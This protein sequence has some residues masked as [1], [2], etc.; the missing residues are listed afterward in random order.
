MHWDI[1]SAAMFDP[2]WKKPPQCPE[3]R[4]TPEDICVLLGVP[5]EIAVS[6]SQ[7]YIY[8]AALDIFS[9]DEVASLHRE[10]VTDPILRNLFG[11]TKYSQGSFQPALRKMMQECHPGWQKGLG[12]FQANIAISCAVNVVKNGAFNWQAA[13]ANLVDD[14]LLF[15]ANQHS[16]PLPPL[17]RPRILIDYGPGLSGRFVMKEH[18]N[19][20]AKGR[21]FVYAPIARGS[22]IPTFLVSYVSTLMT[23]ES[24]SIYMNNGF[25]APKH[26]GIRAVT[27]YFIQAAP[28]QADVIFCSSLQMVDKQELRAGIENA[29][30]LLRDGGVLLLR[31][32]KT[33]EPAESSTIDDMLDIAFASG[34]SSQ[35]ARYFHSIS[36]GGKATP[37]LSAILI[38][39]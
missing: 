14:T 7:K 34:F 25:F 33:R 23:K 16:Y 13:S 19:A 22:F 31:S 18:L 4:V 29:Y 39:S 9:D 38:K 30:P 24:M 8:S 20:L 2:P 28:G 15:D 27:N 21:P 35:S 12:T 17:S 11:E 3:D 1:M 32:Q 37:T 5:R 36:G 26:E 10:P 6:H